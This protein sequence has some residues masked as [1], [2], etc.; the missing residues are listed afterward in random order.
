MKK[1]AI[2]QSSYIPWRGYFDLINSVDEFIFYDEV[3][4]TKQ[5]WRNRNRILNKNDVKWIT[6]PVT[7][8]PLKTKIF[9]IKVQDKK[10]A[11]KQLQIIKEYYFK[12]KFFE[13]VYPKISQIF[14]SISSN[15]LT[16]INQIIIKEFCLLLDIN[17]KFFNSMSFP[18][19]LNL[20]SSTDRLIEI[21]KQTKASTYVTGSA[22]KNYLE[23]EKFNKNKISVE[24]FNYGICKKYQQSSIIFNEKLSIIDCMMFCGFEGKNFLNTKNSK[25]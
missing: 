17:V 12:A 1:I 2:L 4:F 23:T 6:L 16:N 7:K 5:D 24:F 20:P 11:L 14:N 18:S 19:E 21:A 8:Q 10:W 13:I 9:N 22:A 25:Y 3:Q 15:Y